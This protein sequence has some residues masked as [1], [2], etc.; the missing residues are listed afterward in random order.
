MMRSIGQLR[1]RRIGL[2]IILRFQ[3]SIDKTKY[4][5]FQGGLIKKKEIAGKNVKKA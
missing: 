4:A 1:R 5:I 3:K 2:P